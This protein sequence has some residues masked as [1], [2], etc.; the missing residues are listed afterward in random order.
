MSR[1][2]IISVCHIWSRLAPRIMRLS[3]SWVDGLSLDFEVMYGVRSSLWCR[4][5][6]LIFLVNVVAIVLIASELFLSFSSFSL[7]SIMNLPT[8]S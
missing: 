7:K 3:S 5:I 2:W 8:S 6:M 4:R 1:D